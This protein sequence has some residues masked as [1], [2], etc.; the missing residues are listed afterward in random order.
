[1]RAGRGLGRYCEREVR[2][3]HFRDTYFHQHNNMGSFAL[4]LHR[5]VIFWRLF[6]WTIYIVIYYITVLA[7]VGVFPQT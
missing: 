1:M 7:G 6:F 2:R 4:Q 5:S 3:V